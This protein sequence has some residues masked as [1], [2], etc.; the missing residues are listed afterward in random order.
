MG[1]WGWTGCYIELMLPRCNSWILPAQVLLTGVN[2]LALFLRQP[3]HWERYYYCDISGSRNTKHIHPA[4]IFHVNSRDTQIF[5]SLFHLV[6]IVWVSLEEMS[7]TVLYI[8]YNL[9]LF[10]P[11]HWNPLRVG[12]KHSCTQGRGSVRGKHVLVATEGLLLSF[13]I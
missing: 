1:L 5:I 9:L 3:A 7:F 4:C 6:Q 11:Q 10:S 12:F 2:G 13:I 8:F